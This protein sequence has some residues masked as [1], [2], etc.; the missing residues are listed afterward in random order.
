MD[1]TR[2][3]GFNGVA[4]IATIVKPNRGVNPLLQVFQGRFQAIGIF[5]ATHSKVRF[6][7]SGTTEL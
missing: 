2:A 1:P 5:G 7:T 3:K 6:A 4:T